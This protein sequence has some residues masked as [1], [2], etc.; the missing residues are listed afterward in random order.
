MKKL[1][2]WI[3]IQLTEQMKKNWLNEIQTPIEMSRWKLVEWIQTQP[4]EQMKESR[5]IE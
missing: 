2:D 4:G 5:W 3:Q 1:A